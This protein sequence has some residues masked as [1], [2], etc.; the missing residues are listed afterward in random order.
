MIAIPKM[1]LKKR[2][3]QQPHVVI[4]G[5]GASLAAF[6][7]GDKNGRFLPLMHNIISTL[8]LEPILEEHGV[9]YNDEGFEAFYSDLASDPSNT[10]LLLEIE[11]AIFT[12]T[13]VGTIATTP[14]LKLQ[15]SQRYMIIFSYL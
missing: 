13:K 7:K 11:K 12:Y 3:S 8:K 2:E 1:N 14:P 10:S 5:A 4:L 15:T 6:P 9:N